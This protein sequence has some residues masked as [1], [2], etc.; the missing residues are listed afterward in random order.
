[1]NFEDYDDFTDEQKNKSFNILQILI[2]NKLDNNE[3]FFIG[4]LSGNET[5]LT[6]E[7]LNNNYNID[8]YLYKVLSFRS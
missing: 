5:R 4:R 3:P 6:G 2:K 7:I 8:N 1:M